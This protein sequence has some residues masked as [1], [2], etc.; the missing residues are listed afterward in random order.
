MKISK[1][2]VYKSR[3]IGGWWWQCDRCG[4]PSD[5]RNPGPFSTMV[6]AF[7]GALD[8]ARACAIWVV[9]AA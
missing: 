5:L 3:F 2:I 7:R 8:H 4:S 6:S 9:D 1:P